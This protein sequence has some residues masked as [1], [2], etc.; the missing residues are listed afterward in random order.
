[1]RSAEPPRARLA[2]RN[3]DSAPS[4]ERRSAGAASGAQI[5]PTSSDRNCRRAFSLDAAHAT[6]KRP[7]SAFTLDATFYSPFVP[8]LEKGACL[9]RSSPVSPLRG[10][11]VAP[12]WEL[13]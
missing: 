1:M 2:V 12:E 10:H 9:A 8:L 13:W 3:A 7:I 5:L 4:G 6:R 11:E